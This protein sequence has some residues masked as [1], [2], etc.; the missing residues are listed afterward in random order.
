MA[1]LL[2]LVKKNLVSGLESPFYFDRL[3]SI[4]YSNLTNASFESF[5]PSQPGPPVRFSSI[6]ILATANIFALL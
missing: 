5:L 6:F 2:N 1:I 3:V 4:S